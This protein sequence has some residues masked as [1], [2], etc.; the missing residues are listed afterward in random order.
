MS[1]HFSTKHG[2]REPINI[3]YMWSMIIMM[4]ITHKH[5]VSQR[6][7]FYKY[8]AMIEQTMN[9]NS[10]RVQLSFCQLWSLGNRTALLAT[11]CLYVPT[12][13]FTLTILTSLSSPWYTSNTRANGHCVGY[14]F[15]VT[16]KHNVIN[17]NVPVSL[18][19]FV[20]LLQTGNVLARPT[21]SKVM[22][23]CRCHRWRRK[24]DT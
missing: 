2:K 3:H 20:T 13:V 16:E 7:M 12:S 22:D 23:K 9:N 8:L 18:V 1:S 6:L 19:P 10:S 14:H 5:T 15:V 4:T 17:S 24:V 21:H 11:G